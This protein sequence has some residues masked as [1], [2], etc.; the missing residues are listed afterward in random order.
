LNGV[1]VN[2]II[3]KTKPETMNTEWLQGNFIKETNVEIRREI[4][5]KLGSSLLCER[6]KAKCIDKIGN[7]ELLNLNINTEIFRPYLK[8]INPSTGTI[9]IEGVHPS[10]NTVEKALNWRNKIDSNNKGNAAWFQHGDVLLKPKDQ[11][12]NFKPLV[13]N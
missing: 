9:H 5:K 10:C 3:V 11:T 6:L 1:K 2:E 4:V 13:L 12:I 7:Y 8:M